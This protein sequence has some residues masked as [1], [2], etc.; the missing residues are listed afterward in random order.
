LD[1]KT[2]SQLKIGAKVKLFG[3][4]GTVV[5]VL[6]NSFIVE[7]MPEPTWKR[8]RI[9]VKF[10]RASNIDYAYPQEYFEQ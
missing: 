2:A 4:R 9:E 10:D 5:D 1:A 3:D 8:H 6:V 7:Y